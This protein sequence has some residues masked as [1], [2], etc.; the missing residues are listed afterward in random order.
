LCTQEPKTNIVRSR[1]VGLGKAKA[2]AKART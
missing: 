2:K 1:F